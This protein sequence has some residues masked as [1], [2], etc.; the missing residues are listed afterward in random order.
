MKRIKV[1]GMGVVSAL[2]IGCEENLNALI[3]SR[4]G[5]SA[6]NDLSS[7]LRVPV[8]A[9][10]ESNES[11]KLRLNL[12]KD[13]V[14]SRTAL[15]GAL[16][17]KEAV[18]LANIPSGKRIGLISS[19]TVGGMDLSEDFYAEYLQ[20][21][22][23]ANMDYVKGHDCA[24]STNFIADQCGIKG[25]RTTLSTACSSAANAIMMGANLLDKGLLDYVV[26][27]GTDA[28]CRFTLNG[29]NTL[30]ILDEEFCKPLDAERQGLNLGEGAGYLVLTTADSP[31]ETYA[32]LSGFANANDAFHQTASSDNGEGAFRAMN[33]ALEMAD[34]TA[35]KV[36]YINMHGTGT[37][38]NDASE[39]AALIRVFGDKLPYTSTTKSFTGHCLAAAGGIEAVYSVLALNKDVVYPNLRIT[40]PIEGLQTIMTSQRVEHLRYVL[41]N[42]F[43][44]GG[45]CSS[46]L[47]SC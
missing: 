18:E 2:G 23:S 44:F 36:D 47:F 21:K 8:G 17:A 38:N 39:T 7:V 25:F 42:S 24:T 20:D 37:N 11:L 32:V 3:E 19:T 34:I 27:G 40:T 4:S 31:G 9:L 22:S 28:L 33:Q 30:H 41:S 1:C 5:I 10:Q 12:S 16:A 35:D 14:I 26:V 29:F 13:S 46:L 43:G 6:Q 15:I 45:N